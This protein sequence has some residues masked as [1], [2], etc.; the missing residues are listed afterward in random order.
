[1]S[2]TLQTISRLRRAMPRNKDVMDVCDE[3]ERKVVGQSLIDAAR[4]R[5]VNPEKLTRAQIQR[6]YRQRKKAKA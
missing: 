4:G 5:D 2:D 1:M 3:L 6:R